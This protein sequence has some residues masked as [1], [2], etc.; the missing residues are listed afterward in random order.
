MIRWAACV[1]MRVQ[2]RPAPDFSNGSPASR[3]CRW[4]ASGFVPRAIGGGEIRQ[5]TGTAMPADTLATLAACEVEAEEAAVL[6]EALSDVDIRATS[7]ALTLEHATFAAD[8]QLLAIRVRSHVD[9]TLLDTLS[10][11]RLVTTL[12][13]GYDHIELG[14]RYRRLQRA[15]LRRGD[16][17]RAHVRADPRVVAQDPPSR[18]AHRPRRLFATGV[19]WLTSA[20]APWAR[21][22]PVTSGC[23]WF[24]SPMVSAW[25]GCRYVLHCCHA[26][27]LLPISP[28]R[29]TPVIPSRFSNCHPE[30]PRGISAAASDTEIPHV[31]R[32]DINEGMTVRVG[33][34]DGHGWAFRRRRRPLVQ[35]PRLVY[36]EERNEPNLRTAADRS[37][38]H[39]Q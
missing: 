22:A 25:T 7:D 27:P 12:S 28:S 16:G 35:W 13:T 10:R 15:D 2:P 19:A 9:A 11:L 34:Q 23:S 4:R 31:V 17:R 38:P 1:V 36:R 24:A 30:P 21:S 18:H 39:F 20:D 3:R 26:A 32:N 37:R 5:D 14:A 6:R 8:A 29:P 33:R